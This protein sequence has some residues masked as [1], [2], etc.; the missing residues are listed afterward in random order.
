MDCGY[1][2]Y[3]LPVSIPLYVTECVHLQFARHIR[4][5]VNGDGE[6]LKVNRS[7]KRGSAAA[8]ADA[9]KLLAGH[10]RHA[11]NALQLE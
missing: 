6:R 7:K 11:G 4:N 10:P 1:P 9:C 5:Y 2:S 3:P 8:A